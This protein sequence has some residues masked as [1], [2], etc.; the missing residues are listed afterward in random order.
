MP[1]MAATTVTVAR[2]IQPATAAAN[3]KALERTQRLLAG[4]NVQEALTLEAGLLRLQF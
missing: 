3:L 1:D 2:R 4:T